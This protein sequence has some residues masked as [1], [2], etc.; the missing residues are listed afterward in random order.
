MEELFCPWYFRISAKDEPGVLAAIAG[1][2]AIYSISIESVIQKGRQQSG[3]VS[4]VITTHTAQE[5]S[6]R[7]ALAEI[8]L[9]DV[10]CAPTVRIRMLAETASSTD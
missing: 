6:V 8:D 9:L 2:L 3:P 5:S 4:I 10:V 1:I 7:E